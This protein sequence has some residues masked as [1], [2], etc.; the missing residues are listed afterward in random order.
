MPECCLI[1]LFLA[2]SPPPP[3]PSCPIQGWT[4]YAERRILS[5]IYG[6]EKADLHAAIGLASLLKTIQEF[7][8]QGP[9]GLRFTQ[10]DVGDEGLGDIDPDE[11]YSVVP[12][13]KVRGGTGR[14]RRDLGVH[15]PQIGHFF[16]WRMRNF[17]C[18]CHML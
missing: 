2:S 3:P 15:Q 1:T 13:E 8:S 12:Y 18:L 4:V 11:V 16:R 5:K 9:T 10:L 14:R 17:L 6:Q 7:E